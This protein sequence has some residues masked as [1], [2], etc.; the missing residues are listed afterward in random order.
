M[1]YILFH[2]QLE[3]ALL[4]FKVICIQELKHMNLPVVH[5]VLNLAITKSSFMNFK[6]F[7]KWQI[8]ICL[9]LI[10]GIHNPKCIHNGMSRKPNIQPWISPSLAL[11]KTQTYGNKC[12]Q[13]SHPQNV[14]W[15]TNSKRLS[16]LNIFPTFVA[17]A[18]PQN[19]WQQLI[20]TL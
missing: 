13:S 12:K 17:P 5:L 20:K 3:H 11:A 18:K 7:A 9:E 8:I 2:N 14:N 6:V 16:M 4:A 10:L 15:T 1:C 19:R